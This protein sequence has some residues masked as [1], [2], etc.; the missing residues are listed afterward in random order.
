[1]SLCRKH[2]EWEYCPECIIDAAWGA[3]DPYMGTIDELR[4]ELADQERYIETLLPEPPSGEIVTLDLPLDVTEYC[5]AVAKL[6][7]H[8]VQDV[9]RIVLAMELVRRGVEEP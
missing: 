2:D 6:A 9:I 3:L 1:M 7:G 5:E 8:T 4:A